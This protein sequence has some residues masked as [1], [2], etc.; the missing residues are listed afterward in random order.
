MNFTN[1]KPEDPSVLKYL[2][3]TLPALLAWVGLV[4]IALFLLHLAPTPQTAKH[5]GS[6]PVAASRIVH[7]PTPGIE[8][9]ILAK[10]LP[11]HGRIKGK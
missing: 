2:L 9:A 5:T 8:D 3:C 1:N 11:E 7:S 6:P 4:A 10:V